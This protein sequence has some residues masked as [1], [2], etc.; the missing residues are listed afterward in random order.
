MLPLSPKMNIPTKKLPL[1]LALLLTL[2]GALPAS[3]QR[4]GATAA[5]AHRLDSLRQRCATM[6]NT[7]VL[8][9]DPL[10]YRLIGAPT[11]Y[12]GALSHVFSIDTTAEADTSLQ[13]AIN[14]ALARQYVLRPRS[15]HRYDAQYRNQDL[16][17]VSQVKTSDLQQQMS[18]LLDRDQE[19]EKANGGAAS[20][21]DLLLPD[22]IGLRVER[23]N[24]WKTSALFTL[25][26]TQN[27]FSEKWYKGGNNSG[28]LLSSLT[29]TANYN[30]QQR[31]TWENR[32]LMRLGFITTPSDTCH[33][34]ITNNDKL[35][36]YSK[37]GVKARK[38]FY[39]TLSLEANTQFMPGYRTNDR[40]TYSDFLAPLDVYASL[41]I[42]Y[43]PTLKN[44]NTFS[45]A[46][47][48][49]SYKLRYI[50]TDDETVHK[51]YNMVDKHSQED[52]GSKVELNSKFTL[53]KNLTWKCRAYY[54][55]S[56]EY[57]EAELENVLGYAFSKYL[58]TELYTLWRFDD[59]RSHDYYDDNLG[60]FQFKEYFTF[61]ISYQF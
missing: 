18:Q 51:A 13:Q 12:S 32:L 29:L 61:G 58:S 28:T 26:F 56:Y 36:L 1:L 41:G 59:N 17:T 21:V 5:F 57:A 39:Y 11:F 31:V 44:G 60:Y 16:P 42:D 10:Y 40:R 47:L 24:F 49:L 19:K 14:S 53:A 27:Y 43:K 4:R 20:D 9:A 38:S 22:D 3:A 46:L 30:D 23:P 50:R 8:D 45:V 55:T 52:Y 25:Q 37:L 48:P 6:S 54:F 2:C 34:Y 15:F 35:N 33:T 7:D